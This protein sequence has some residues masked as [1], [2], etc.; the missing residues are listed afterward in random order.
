MDYYLPLTSASRDYYP[1]QSVRIA[2]DKSG[3]PG[4]HVSGC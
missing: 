1:A 4:F 2:V 3:T